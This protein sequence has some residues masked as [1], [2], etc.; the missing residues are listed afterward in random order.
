VRLVLNVVEPPDPRSLSLDAILV[1]FGFDPISFPE[2]CKLAEIKRNQWGGMIV[3]EK[4]DDQH[5]GQPSLP[6]RQRGR[7][8][9]A[10]RTT[11]IFGSRNTN[12]LGQIV[13][14][15]DDTGVRDLVDDRDPRDRTLRGDTTERGGVRQ[16]EVV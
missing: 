15:T 12:H 2:G 8:V 11:A 7:L 5:R 6:R 13:G 16:D 10:G 4:Q 1:A 3:G 9:P 14:L